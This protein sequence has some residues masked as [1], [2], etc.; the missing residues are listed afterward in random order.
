MKIQEQS[1]DKG[2]KRKSLLLRVLETGLLDEPH[3]NATPPF[4][5]LTIA[6]HGQ[7]SS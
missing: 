6:N 4:S 1:K 7:S 5:S 2:S 3:F